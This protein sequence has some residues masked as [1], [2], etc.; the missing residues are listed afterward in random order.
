[1]M[2]RAIAGYL[3]KKYEKTKKGAEKAEKVALTTTFI[4]AKAGIHERI[5]PL[6]KLDATLPLRL[7]R[8]GSNN[9][10][11]TSPSWPDLIRPSTK[12]KADTIEKQKDVDPRIKSEDDG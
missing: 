2:R 4:P 3:S 5:M 6:K 10:P 8:N 1:M 12:R 11:S 9:C 7:I